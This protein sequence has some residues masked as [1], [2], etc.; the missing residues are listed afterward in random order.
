M[1]T[2]MILIFHSKP[3]D[4]PADIS[5]PPPSPSPAIPQITV[6]P[7]TESPSWKPAVKSPQGKPPM[8]P[9]KP[10][11]DP[12]LLSSYGITT[13][14]PVR[15]DSAPSTPT[16]HSKPDTMRPRANSTGYP[17]SPVSLEGK[18]NAYLTDIS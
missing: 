7:K 18:Y 3:A 12:N 2:L 8:T 1:Y 13:A 14:D 10:N 16:T 11:I 6:A 17:Q 15:K 5:S 4:K 9:P